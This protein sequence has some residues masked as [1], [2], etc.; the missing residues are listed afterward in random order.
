MTGVAVKVQLRPDAVRVVRVTAQPP[1][2]V[3]PAQPTPVRVVAAGQPGPKG[4]R[5]PPGQALRLAY[6]HV[7]ALPASVWLVNHN[8]G[9]HPSVTVIDSAGSQW[10]G[11]VNHDDLNSLTI[12]FR[13]QFSGRAYCV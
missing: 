8:L 6:D 3:R 11:A 4:D 10:F 1:V 7:Q 5:G 9:F 12:T 13:A 2:Q